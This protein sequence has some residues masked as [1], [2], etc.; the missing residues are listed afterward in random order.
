MRFHEILFLTDAENFNFLSYIHRHVFLSLQVSSV[1]LKKTLENKKVLFL[2]KYDLGG[3]QYQNKKALFTDP[4]FSDGFGFQQWPSMHC[5]RHYKG[6]K[7]NIAIELSWS[8]ATLLFTYSNTNA[9]PWSSKTGVFIARTHNN[10]TG[11][12]QRIQMDFIDFPN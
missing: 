2:K 5:I 8:D 9:T 7:W 3:S 4:I 1:W 12:T 6:Q 10:F 11:T